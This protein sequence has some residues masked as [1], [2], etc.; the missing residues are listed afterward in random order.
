MQCSFRQLKEKSLSTEVTQMQWNPKMDLLALANTQ[1]EVWLHRLNWQRVWTLSPPT[2]ATEGQGVTG[3]AW[4]P[5]G[6]VLGV[7]YQSGQV[8]L[9]DVEKA[10]VLHTST[11]SHP[12]SCMT[13]QEAEEKHSGV[14][15]SPAHAD[16]SSSPASSP[17]ASQDTAADF[18][19]RLTPLPKGYSATDKANSEEEV[20]EDNKRL[21]SQTRLNI[22]VVGDE[23]GSIYLLAYGLFSM[24]QLAPEEHPQAK[25]GRLLSVTLSSDLQCLS[26]VVQHQ[27]SAD[28]S[29]PE[30][31]VCLTTYNTSLLATRSQELA[32]LGMKYGQIATILGYMENTLRSMSEAW[33]DI[34][35]EMDNK[36]A[37]FAETID[38]KDPDWQVSDEFL[39]LL[40]WGKASPE[41]QSF[42]LNT[43]TEKGLKKLGLSIDNSYSNIEKLVLNHLQRAGQALL[44]HLSE[45]KGLSLWYDK[46]GML[47]LNT[48]AVQ[49]A[50]SCAGSFMLK[51]N[52]LLQVIDNSMKNFKAFFR[53]VYAVMLRLAGEQVPSEVSKMSQKDL[54]FVAE[55]L[56]ENLTQ[57]TPSPGRPKRFN[58]EKVGQYLNKKDEDLPFPQDLSKIPWE[59]FMQSSTYLKGSE[60]LFPH[61]QKK[62]LYQVFNIT[63]TAVDSALE[64]PA[65]V[66][67]KSFNCLGSLPLYSMVKREDSQHKRLPVLP[68]SQ[69][70]G[71]EPRHVFTLVIPDQDTRSRI[72]VI[73]HPTQLHSELLVMEGAWLKVGGQLGEQ[74]TKRCSSHKIL[75]VS[76]YDEGTLALLLQEGEGECCPVLALL[77]LMALDDCG[78]A[79]LE[80]LQT[81]PLTATVA[82]IG[83][84]VGLC[85]YDVGH[86][87]TQYRYLENADPGVMAVGGERKVGAV[88]YGH[89]RRLRLFDMNAEEEGDSDEDISDND[90]QDL[91]ETT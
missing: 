57:E 12:V 10:E 66:I 9:C 34:L 79:V 37:K 13:W 2:G 22:L 59:T 33:E 6:Q 62:S 71:G 47:G 84:R 53:W 85:M 11:L 76:Y 52:E 55:F 51:A 77:P 78:F 61:H 83:D 35:L 7:G 3:L 27:A 74:E 63:K 43:L 72:L 40:M 45:L 58:L 50:W 73:R 88:L 15:A 29:Q 91:N 41:L 18:L 39:Q 30:H 64:G 56:Q 69:F 31:T 80:V 36:L 28:T 82:S 49:E 32:T 24:G 8:V 60:L 48:Q 70:S 4:R 89:Q 16:Q 86:Q 14:P 87:I 81:F 5:D 17:T 19:P 23:V 20:V 42:L 38:S 54:A 65:A 26:A 68:M 1:G 21:S 67:G 25:G 75:D 46:Y 90:M 44:F